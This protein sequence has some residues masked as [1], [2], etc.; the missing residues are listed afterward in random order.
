MA[1]SMLS[2]VSGLEGLSPYRKSSRALRNE[3]TGFALQA[4]LGL[5]WINSASVDGAQRHI[6]IAMHCYT[7]WG[8]SDVTRLNIVFLGQ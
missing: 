4:L 3:K 2:P 7:N 8:I 6:Y 1:A 5:N